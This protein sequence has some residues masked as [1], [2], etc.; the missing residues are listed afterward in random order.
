[1]S[2]F[3]YMFN[4]SKSASLPVLAGDYLDVLMVK[5][6]LSATRIATSSV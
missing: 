5:P 4:V 6:A 1:M 3:L 2:R